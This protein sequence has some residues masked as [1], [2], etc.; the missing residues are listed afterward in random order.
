M[1]LKHFVVE[2]TS[3]IFYVSHMTDKPLVKRADK[4]T[5][6]IV[7]AAMGEFLAHGVVSSVKCDV[8]GSLLKVSKI[9]DEAWKIECLCD[10]FNDT[11]RGI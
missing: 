6:E 5:L 7:D 9:G 3:H 2:R 11:L 8:C 4:K 1:R 10:K